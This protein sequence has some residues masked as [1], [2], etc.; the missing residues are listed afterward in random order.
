MDVE[1]TS[2]TQFL[3][4]LARGSLY[5]LVRCVFTPRG[6]FKKLLAVKDSVWEEL[7]SGSLAEGRQVPVRTVG[8]CGGIGPFLLGIGYD[9]GV[10]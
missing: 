5:D 1:G 8:G 9:L 7:G 4:H 2:L 3:K 10:N 6:L